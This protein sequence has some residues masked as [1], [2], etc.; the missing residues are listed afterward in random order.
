MLRP[1]STSLKGR[2]AAGASLKRI[3]TRRRIAFLMRQQQ[4]RLVWTSAQARW[5][6]GFDTQQQFQIA[7]KPVDVP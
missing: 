4:S 3:D 5:S 2:K 7:H 6:K 1:D